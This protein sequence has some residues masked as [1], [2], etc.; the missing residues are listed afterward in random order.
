MLAKI[1]IARFRKSLI[2]LTLLCAASVAPFLRADEPPLPQA[3]R[4]RLESG[5]VIEYTIPFDRNALQDSLRIGNDLIALTSSGVLLRFQLPDVRLVQERAETLEVKCLGRGEGD[6]ILTGLADGRICRV[7]LATLEL[8]EITKLPAPPRWIGWLPAI[9]NR[10]AGPV[11][12]SGLTKSTVHDLATQKTFTVDHKATTFLLDTAGRL[13]LGA[14]NGEW[15]GRVTRVDLAKGT[16]A[17][18]EPPPSRHPNR[19]AFWHGIY[20]FIELRDHQVWAFGGVSHVG[21]NSREITRVDEDKPRPLFE[22]ETHAAFDDKPDAPPPALPISHVIE[23][24]ESLLVFSYDDVFRVDKTLKTWNRVATLSLHYRWGR[25]DAMGSYPSVRAVHPASGNGEPYI[26]ATRADG[27]VLLKDGQ[28]TAH[29]LPGQ[30]GADGIDLV[31]NTAEGTFFFEDADAEDGDVLPP[32]TLGARGWSVVPL[33]PPA[34]D[35]P[36]K[37]AMDEHEDLDARKVTCVLVDP[38]SGEIYTVTGTDKRGGTLVTARRVASREK[39]PSSA[40]HRRRNRSHVLSLPARSGTPPSA[41]SNDLKTANG[42][43][44]CRCPTRGAA[45]NSG[46]STR[47]DHPGFCSTLLTTRCGDSST[48][49]TQRTRDSR[50]W[51]S[52]KPASCFKR[53]PRSLGRTVRCFWRPTR[54][55][56]SLT[57]QEETSRSPTSRSRRNRLSSCPATPSAASGWAGNTDSGWS[58]PPERPWTRLIACRRFSITRSGP[59]HPTRTT[60]T[61]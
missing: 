41:S 25:P 7:N 5:R 55:S 10:P 18:I 45:T 19:Q 4:V 52:T 33:D 61:A 40:A 2:P 9:G 34:N 46:P 21:F 35:P 58:T 48:A 36:P 54:V 27:Y 53:T 37:P 50:A 15:A 17:K 23:E 14:D 24:R 57:L 43:P 32:W 31:V 6:A 3:R 22:N 47:T 59:S 28:V 1:L 26:L 38:T 49:R 13:W 30:F 39:Q 12:V 56:D 16:L 51:S 8:T 42:R 44:S 29:G 11:A 60:T 20:G